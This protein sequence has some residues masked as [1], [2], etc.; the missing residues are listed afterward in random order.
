MVMVVMVVCLGRLSGGRRKR[1]KVRYVS[2][3]PRVNICLRIS[4]SRH[5]YALHMYMLISS[6]L[7]LIKTLTYHHKT[8]DQYRILTRVGF[9]PTPPKRSD[10]TPHYS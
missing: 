8:L 10:N 4:Y 3:L 6:P 7:S 2:T 9:E 5:R 1:E